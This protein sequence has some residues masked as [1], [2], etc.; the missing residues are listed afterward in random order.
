VLLG[1][2]D[3]EQKANTPS[4]TS[5]YWFICPTRAK[6]F[7]WWN[8]YICYLLLC[9]ILL[10]FVTLWSSDITKVD[11]SPSHLSLIASLSPCLIM[12]KLSLNLSMFLIRHSSTKL[13][14][15]SFHLSYP[16][17]WSSKINT[18]FYH[19]WTLL[20]FLTKERHGTKEKIW[21]HECLYGK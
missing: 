8:L 5:P 9:W 15:Y 12:L 18:Y 11:P 19:L 17:I 21:T 14:P 16:P 2:F 10:N 7:G 20:K 1:E 13:N 3:F 4:F 6:C